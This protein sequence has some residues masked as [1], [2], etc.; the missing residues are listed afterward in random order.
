M[1]CEALAGYALLAMVVCSTRM[2]ISQAQSEEMTLV[3]ADSAFSQY[4]VDLLR[5]GR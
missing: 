3:S 2:L 1:L 4:E 5:A